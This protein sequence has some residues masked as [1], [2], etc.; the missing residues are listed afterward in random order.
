[1]G[2]LLTRSRP[3]CSRTPPSASSL[4]PTGG[5]RCAGGAAV[6]VQAGARLTTPSVLRATG[7]RLRVAPSCQQPAILSSHRSVS[8]PQ[9]REFTPV[10]GESVAGKATD[11]MR[12]SGRAGRQPIVLIASDQES[13]SRSL[14]SIL[15][16]SGYTVLK[17]YTGAQTL[18]RAR[19]AQPD[20]IIL[21]AI[22]PDQDA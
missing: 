21:D 17:A 12:D 6:K 19:A 20:A 5:E 16:P 22:L 13:S 10:V 18:E 7:A 4:G 9:V 2:G 8:T 3:V 11:S 1:M 15:A 14:E